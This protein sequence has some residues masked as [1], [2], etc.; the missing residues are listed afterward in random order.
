V[1]GAERRKGEGKGMDGIGKEGEW[2][3]G[4]PIYIWS[5]FTDSSIN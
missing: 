3:E 1:R 4:P 5:T 2:K